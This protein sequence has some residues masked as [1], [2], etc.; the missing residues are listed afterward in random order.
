MAVGPVVVVAVGVAAGVAAAA[1][2]AAVVAA[3]EVAA[4]EDLAL[5]VLVLASGGTPLGLGTQS[6]W[7]LAAAAPVLVVALAGTR[8]PMRV[9]VGLTNRLW[10]RMLGDLWAR[11]NCTVASS[12]LP[13]PA[14]P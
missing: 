10:A 2:S 3:V 4:P 8:L 6:R 7:V 14:M 13:M 5:M 1:S 11:C 12:A 9:H